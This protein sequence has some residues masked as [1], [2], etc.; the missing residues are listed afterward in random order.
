MHNVYGQPGTRRI[1]RIMK[2][3]LSKL[4]EQYGE[5]SFHIEEDEQ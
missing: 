5:E 4:Q 2:R 1:T 3:K